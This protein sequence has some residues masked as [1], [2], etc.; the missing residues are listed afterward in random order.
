MKRGAVLSLA[1]REVMGPGWPQILLADGAF[2]IERLPSRLD[3]LVKERRN[4]V[5]KVR[6]NAEFL[7]LLAD[8]EFCCELTEI[9]TALLANTLWL[10]GLELL[11]LELLA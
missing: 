9:G 8:A 2:V 10:P 7:A 11:G 4:H 6:V 5:E 1:V 3:L